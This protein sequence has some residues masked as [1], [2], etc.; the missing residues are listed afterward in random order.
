MV[1]RSVGNTIQLIGIRNACREGQ[2]IDVCDIDH[3]EIL[4]QQ[5]TIESLS[6]SIAAVGL[7]LYSFQS[8]IK[9][10]QKQKD[11]PWLLGSPP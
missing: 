3:F 1:N 2:K 9:W 4:S 7:A 11:R 8:L 5:V 6:N 10:M